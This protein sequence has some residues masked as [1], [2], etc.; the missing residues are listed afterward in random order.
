MEICKKKKKVGAEMTVTLKFKVKF[1]Y[2]L[3]NRCKKSSVYRYKLT[4]PIYH[5]TYRISS[6][7]CSFFSLLSFLSISLFKQS[8]TCSSFRSLVSPKITY[9]SPF[10]MIKATFKSM[11]FTSAAFETMVTPINIRN[12]K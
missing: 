9:N 5:Y 7:L 10:R 3:C 4:I 2:Y 11:H 12:R 6:F 1:F 8:Q